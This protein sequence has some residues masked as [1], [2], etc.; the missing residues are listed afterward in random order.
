MGAPGDE[1]CTNVIAA[2]VGKRAAAHGF[3]LGIDLDE[4]LA[5]GSK[6]T[7][8]LRRTPDRPTTYA[9]ESE[10]IVETGARGTRLSLSEYR[11]RMGLVD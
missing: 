3:D 6:L 8:P 2:P 7:I 9:G 11:K 10:A 1:T 5:P 4:G